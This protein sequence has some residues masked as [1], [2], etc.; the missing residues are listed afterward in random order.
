[1]RTRNMMFYAYAFKEGVQRLILPT[2]ISLDYT[3]L[4]IKLPFN[5]IL[6]V[7]KILKNFIL[8]TQKIDPSKFSMIIN[9][10]NIILMPPN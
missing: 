1:M 2:P 9:K 10:G 8:S 7:M 6:K 4:A 5:K 3:D